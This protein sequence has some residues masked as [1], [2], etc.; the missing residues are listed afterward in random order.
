MKSLRTAAGGV[1]LAASIAAPAHG[2]P[3]DRL[4]VARHADSA[5]PPTCDRTARSL[6]QAITPCNPLGRSRG[7]GAGAGLL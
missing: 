5:T 4:P 1:L 2:A 3:T 7:P 6:P